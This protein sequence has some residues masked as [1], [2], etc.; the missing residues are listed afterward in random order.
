[1]ESNLKTL[2]LDNEFKDML[3]IEDNIDDIDYVDYSEEIKNL[4]QSIKGFK[5]GGFDVLITNPHTLAESI[6]LHS[7]CHDALY[8]KYSYNLVHLLQSKDHIHRLWLRDNQYTQYYYMQDMFEYE[9]KQV[10]IDEEVYNRLM[11]KEKI[12]LSAFDNNSME[13]VTTSEENLKLIFGKM[14][15]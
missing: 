7:I 14:F 11:E 9:G 12:M 10:S 15:C 4:I 3:A 8:F 2:D 1:M 6:S 5:S 13:E